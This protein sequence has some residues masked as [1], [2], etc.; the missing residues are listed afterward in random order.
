MNHNHVAII[1][2][3]FGALATAVR[4]RQSGIDDIVLIERADDVGGVWRDNAY[5]G[6]AVDVKSDLYSLS[7]AKTAD[8]GTLPDNPADSVFTVGLDLGVIYNFSETIRLAMVFEN[9]LKPNY[10][11][12]SD[13]EDYAPT[14]F[15]L[16]ASIFFPRNSGPRPTSRPPTNT[17][18]MARISM[19]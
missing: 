18:M 11:V 9:L 12:F 3:G 19:P 15:K 1:G 7:F 13:G 10:S 8:W 17:A 5:P 6:A 2:T 14:N 4:L 16:G